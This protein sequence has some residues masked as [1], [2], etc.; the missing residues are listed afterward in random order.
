MSG[1]KV[2]HVT[3]EEEIRALR[4]AGWT[5]DGERLV[6]PRDKDVW[7]EY[8]RISSLAIAARSAQFDAEIDQAVRAARQ[9]DR[10][11]PSGE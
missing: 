7:T 3:I 6:H 11:I 5:W 10:E 8:R 2:E 9:L 1:E 4:A